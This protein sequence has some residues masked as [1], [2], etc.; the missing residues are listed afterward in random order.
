MLEAGA[1]KCRGDNQERDELNRLLHQS[2][3]L[4]DEEIKT[5]DKR[6]KKATL[7]ICPHIFQNVTVA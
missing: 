5:A 3:L 7:A 4:T 6:A 1:S 2:E